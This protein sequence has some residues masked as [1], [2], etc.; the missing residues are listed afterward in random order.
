[1]IFFP[2]C[3]LICRLCRVESEMEKP[4]RRWGERWTPDWQPRETASRGRSRERGSPPAFVRYHHLPLLHPR[5]LGSWASRA[6]CFLAVSTLSRHQMVEFDFD[7]FDGRK[8][9]GTVPVS[10]PPPTTPLDLNSPPRPS[11][12][13]RSPLFSKA[14][15][16]HPLRATRLP[17]RR[18]SFAAA[19]VREHS[20][21]CSLSWASSEEKSRVKCVP[22]TTLLAITH[23]KCDL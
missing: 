9:I 23:S 17:T 10:P 1:M 15:A 8:H 4:G 20:L 11:P 2:M 16:A 5:S 14:L 6:R 22:P 13:D 7:I 12:V 19:T 3:R 18:L 21:W